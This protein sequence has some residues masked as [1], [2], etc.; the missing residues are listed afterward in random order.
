MP[1]T[2]LFCLPQ[3]ADRSA[4]YCGG[5]ASLSRPPTWAQLDPNLRATCG[6]VSPTCVGR[7]QGFLILV[8]GFDDELAVRYDGFFLLLPE[9][10]FSACPNLRAVPPGI[11]AA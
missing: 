3:L 2:V 9:Q 4:R 1:G 8:F 11:A 10:C 7:I 5:L 6:S